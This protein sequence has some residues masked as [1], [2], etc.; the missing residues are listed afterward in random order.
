MKENKNAIMSMAIISVLGSMFIIGG[1]ILI[2]TS[3][4]G[5]N[6][7]LNG[8]IVFGIGLILTVTLKL[9]SMFLIIVDLL[10]SIVEKTTE[11]IKIS[12]TNNTE[13]LQ[14]NIT[15]HNPEDIPY[16]V[17]S[18]SVDL[19]IFLEKLK[20]PVNNIEMMSKEELENELEKS[21][22]NNEFEKAAKIRDEL[23]RRKEEK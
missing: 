10:T 14:K 23:K 11:A 5:I 6:P 16:E 8:V 13:F 22:K 1:F 3:F 12:Q 20:M 4:F 7:A 2:V 17:I 19:A 9:F 18:N 21:V 15:I